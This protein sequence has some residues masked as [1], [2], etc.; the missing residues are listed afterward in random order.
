MYARRGSVIAALVTTRSRTLATEVALGSEV[1]LSRPSVVN[2]DVLMTFDRA[3]LMDRA[4]A[5]N[6]EQ[7]AALDEALRYALDLD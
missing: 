7:L 5:L 4:G 1:G 3:L 2:A 6:A